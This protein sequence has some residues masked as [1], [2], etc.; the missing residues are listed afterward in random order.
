MFFILIIASLL[1]LCILIA[2]FNLYFTFFMLIVFNI[3]FYALLIQQYFYGII[4]REGASKYFIFS[5]LST[6]FFFG[7]IKD[8]IAICGTGDFNLVNE[9]IFHILMEYINKGTYEDLF[10]LKY[11]IMLLCFGFFFKLAIFPGHF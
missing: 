4:T 2:T 11:A 5:G 9:Q 8:I 3:S 6:G 1:S 10:I 7:G